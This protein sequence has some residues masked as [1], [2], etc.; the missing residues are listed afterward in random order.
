MDSD[1]FELDSIQLK[2]AVSTKRRGKAGFR[3]KFV[4][5]RTS[6]V[7][8]LSYISVIQSVVIFT[9]LIPTAVVTFNEFLVWMRLPIQFPVNIK[10]KRF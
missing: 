7:E 5:G 6:W 2:K 10:G 1:N 3:D 4:F 9:A 8:A